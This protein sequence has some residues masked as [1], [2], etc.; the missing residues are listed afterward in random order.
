MCKMLMLAVFLLGLLP[1]TSGFGN[2]GLDLDK[3]L[4]F[5][6]QTNYSYVKITP[7]KPLRLT[8]FT[9][10]M[11]VAT[12]LQGKREVILFAYRTPYFDELNVWIE[13]D[14]R[15]SFY[16]SG[17]GVFFNL[18][19]LSTFRTHLC[20]TWSSSTGLAAAWVNGQRSIYRIYRKG[21][22]IRPNGI[23]V[24]GQDPDSFLGD[25]DAEQSFVGEITDVNL[26]D[27]VLT[28]KDIKGLYSHNT[29]VYMPN[30]IHWRGAEFDKYGIVE[31]VKDYI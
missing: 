21:H 5:P 4:L 22:T 18:P 24:L 1:M 29:L 12:E 15:I 31:E 25:F 9:L 17:D 19:P 27:E 28:A 20:F 14:G 16:L 3:V 26:W 2:G 13:S 11:R 6:T 30:V 7:V 23:V 10:C 8:A